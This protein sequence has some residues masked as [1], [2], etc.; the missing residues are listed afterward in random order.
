MIT[1]IWM[2][3]GDH[4]KTALDIREQ[5]FQQELGFTKE[6]DQDVL[7]AYSY[8]LVLLLNDVPVAT[9]RISYDGVGMARLSRICVLKKYRRQ[10]IGDGLVKVLDYKASQLG[11]GHS[12][13]ETVPELEPFYM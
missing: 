10:G 11:M 9:G 12:R 8:H 13:V 7:D 5:V 3:P 2:K 1:S 6:A 4:L